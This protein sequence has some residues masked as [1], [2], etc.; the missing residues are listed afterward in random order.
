MA[1]S[2]LISFH[3]ER[4]SEAPETTDPDPSDWVCEGPE[5]PLL[6]AAR[7]PLRDL[8]VR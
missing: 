8:A 5:A 1:T 7:T 6:R 4:P 2:H 3:A